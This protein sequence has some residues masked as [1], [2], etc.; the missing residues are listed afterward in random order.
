M[1]FHSLSLVFLI[2]CV[3][4]EPSSSEPPVRDPGVNAAIEEPGAP[5]FVPFTFQTGDLT[6][7]GGKVIQHARVVQVRYGGSDGDYIPEVIN[8]T[9]TNMATFYSQ[10]LA[11]G[12]IDWLS[13]EYSIPQPGDQNR[14]GATQIIDRGAF[15]GSIRISPNPMNDGAAISDE[16]I[17]SQNLH[18]QIRAELA[19]QFASGTLPPPDDDK[20]YMIH[21]PAGRSIK[22]DIGQFS[23]TD[24]CGYHSTF[25]YGSQD[26]Y[27]AVLPDVRGDCALAA[28][29]CVGGTDFERQQTVASHELVEA[30][31]DPGVGYAIV[32]PVP[33]P[34]PRA[35]TA[36]TVSGSE[37]EIGDLCKNQR[38]TFAGTDGATYTIQKEFSDQSHSCISGRSYAIP[39]NV[40]SDILWRNTA[41]NTAIWFVNDEVN[42]MQSLP[43][44]LDNNWQIQGVGDFNGDGDSDILWRCVPIAPATS[45][46]SAISGSTAIW[47]FSNGNY[48]MTT[49][50]GW[51]DSSWQVKGIGDFNGDGSSDILWRSTNTN[52]SNLIWYSGNSGTSLAPPDLNTV[53][54]VQGVGDFDGNGNADIFWRCVSPYCGYPEGSVATWYFRNGV[55]SSTTVQAQHIDYS[56]SVVGF[57]DFNGDGA[58]DV[59]WRNTNQ[60]NSISL[61]GSNAASYPIPPA[62]TD[63]QV[64]GV[65][66]FD[67]NGTP[68]ILWRCFPPISNTCGGGYAAG[69]TA[70][71]NFVNGN[72]SSTVFP[73]RL[74]S[75]GTWTIKGVGN[76][77]R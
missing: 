2:G 43:G 47:L 38:T 34:D 9:S 53:W 74:P 73:L 59:L 60:A 27:Y 23:C 69:S 71:W 18:S 12:P 25:K 33:T 48:A 24:Y 37:V 66:D 6:Y 63:W 15:F 19:L 26:V 45:C 11:T 61:W 44:G 50:P 5:A 39:R 68:D 46:G 56:W 52:G 29:H 22:S 42:V 70:I 72:Y 65:G 21:F 54:S 75:D 36:G 28:S 76:F 16:E 3:G 41:G 10:M 7:H 58:T 14:P 30:I 31:T 62:G 40:H 57:G 55:Y 1:R 20:V 49:F 8:T 32:D 35:W 4:Q 17:P 13:Q 51:L 64:Q 67:G 77:D